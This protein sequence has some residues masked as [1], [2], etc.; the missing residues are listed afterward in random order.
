MVREHVAVGHAQWWK[1]G[2]A[3]RGGASW[4]GGA[5]R[6]ARGGFTH[7]HVARVGQL[8]AAR[9]IREADLDMRCG[10]RWVSVWGRRKREVG[11]GVK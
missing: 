9:V 6:R 1:W 2:R 3:A 10:T 8:D 4:G 7:Q 5:G 11:E